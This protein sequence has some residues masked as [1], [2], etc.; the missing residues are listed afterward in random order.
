MYALQTFG[1]TKC[2]GPVVAVDH[3]D[4]KVEEGELFG[5][6]GPNGAG[7]TTTISM[8][9]G[10]LHPTEGRV[11]VLGQEVTPTNTGALRQV[12]AMV[13]TPGFLPYL[14]G[15]ENLRLL[16]RLYA[17]VDDRRVEEVLEQ[18][19]LREAAHRK[20]GG[21][22]TGMKQRLG[23]AAALMHRPRLLVLDE[24]TNGLDPIGMKE[25]RELL[26][27]LAD[28]GITI[29][30]SSHLLHEVEQ[31]CDRVALIHKGRIVA[32]G[33]VRSLLRQYHSLEEMFTAYVTGEE[34]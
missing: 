32:E 19:G 29:F 13:N 18:V 27:A 9:L 31:I 34:R 22:S 28:A 33:E 20:V 15:R 21:Y 23:L 26:R 4:L 6:L 14:S 1:L 24:P 2:F 16:A 11:N 8:I 5:F 3:V 12:G 25:V 10:L 17:D 7:K 30:L